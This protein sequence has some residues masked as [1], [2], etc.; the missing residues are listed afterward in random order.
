MNEKLFYVG[1]QTRDEPRGPRLRR[2]HQLHRD[3][4]QKV[5][6]RQNGPNRI[7]EKVIHLFSFFLFSDCF[8]P[9]VKV[10]DFCNQLPFLIHGY[11]IA[12]KQS[13]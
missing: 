6:A 13:V 12:W 9:V 10:L 4:A 3:S 7:D 8:F 11:N 5:L 1:Q 2:I